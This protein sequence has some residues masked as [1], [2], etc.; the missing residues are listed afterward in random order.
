MDPESFRLF[1]SFPE[2]LIKILN[3]NS[4]KKTVVIDEVQKIPDLLNI[5]HYMIEE[6]KG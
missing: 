3:E 2:R 1:S 6:K 4:D 5:V